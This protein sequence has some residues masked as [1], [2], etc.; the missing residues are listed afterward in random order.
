MYILLQFEFR[1]LDILERMTLIFVEN[2]HDI[3]SK[4][5]S[6]IYCFSFN[7]ENLTFCEEWP[8]HLRENDHFI[9]RG[10]NIVVVIFPQNFATAVNLWTL[11]KKTSQIDMKID[12]IWW[13]N[14][15]FDPKR[16]QNDLNFLGEVAV[17]ILYFVT[18]CLFF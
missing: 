11:R 7:L 10:M 18:F 8:W 2:D 12:L 4:K 6:C 13:L 15:T 9:L 3:L 17:S 5:K 1:D 14:V 16:Q